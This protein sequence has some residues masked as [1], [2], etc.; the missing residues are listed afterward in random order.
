LAPEPVWTLEE[1]KILD[2]TAVQPRASHHTK[3]AS[4]A[5]RKKGCRSSEWKVEPF[6]Q[7]KH[8]NDKLCSKVRKTSND[9]IS[10]AN[11]NLVHKIKAQVL[12]PAIR[13]ATHRFIK[14]F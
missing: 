12:G 3:Y 9:D 5:Q 8:Q 11:L 14:G 7:I 2:P 10:M 1:E 6:E 13:K 4:P